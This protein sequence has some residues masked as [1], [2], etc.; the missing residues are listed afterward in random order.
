[1]CYTNCTNKNGSFC[2]N[3]QACRKKTEISAVSEDVRLKRTGVFTKNTVEKSEKLWY[4]PI[5]FFVE[6]EYTNI[7]CELR[8]FGAAVGYA[9]GVFLWYFVRTCFQ[10][11][12]RMS[13]SKTINIE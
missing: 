6:N 13:G 1:M 5:D 4:F 7:V 11:R 10:R 8:T 12:M 3:E 9:A 2:A